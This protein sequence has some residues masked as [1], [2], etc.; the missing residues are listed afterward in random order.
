MLSPQRGAECCSPL[1]MWCHACSVFTQN[2]LMGISHVRE[3]IPQCRRLNDVVFD[4]GCDVTLDSSCSSSAGRPSSTGSSCH[5]YS[6]RPASSAPNRD[7]QKPD[8]GGEGSITVYLQRVRLATR[9]GLGGRVFIPSTLTSR[10]WTGPMSLH[11]PDPE[12]T[13][14]QE[15]HGFILT[16]I[17]GECGGDEQRFHRKLTIQC[18]ST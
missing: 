12:S 4:C 11:Q 1:G 17:R 15:D 7:P 14:S 16:C 5:C 8:G 9:G 3:T 18:R 6:G 2:V 13:L 10:M